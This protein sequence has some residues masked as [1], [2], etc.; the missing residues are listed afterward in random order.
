MFFMA[1]F[2]SMLEIAKTEES[3]KSVHEGAVLFDSKWQFIK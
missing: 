3:D 2:L 1:L